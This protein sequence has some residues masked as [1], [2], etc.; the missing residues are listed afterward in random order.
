MG[1]GASGRFKSIHVGLHWDCSSRSYRSYSRLSYVSHD[2]A[3]LAAAHKSGFTWMPGIAV[4]GAGFEGSAGTGALFEA[5]DGM[6]RL[7]MLAQD[8]M[9][10]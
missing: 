7:A 1:E 6:L 5:D 2:S 9:S 8:V 3:M 4:A 10:G